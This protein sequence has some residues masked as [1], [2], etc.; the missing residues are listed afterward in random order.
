MKKSAVIKFIVAIL[1]LTLIVGGVAAVLKFTKLGDNLNDIINP[2]FRVEFNGISYTGSNNTF[3]LPQEGRLK[4]DVK[5]TSSYKLKV[6]PN[7]TAETDFTYTVKGR[8]YNFGD[9]DLT[10]YIVADDDIYGE[11]FYIDCTKDYT[12]KGVLS[13]IWGDAGI[14]LN[15]DVQYPYKLTVISDSGEEVTILLSPYVLSVTLNPDHIIF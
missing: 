6:T 5:C 15:G 3:V 14:T 7:V 1:F 12:L 8:I 2:V 13:R 9:E 10:G 4:F 11:C